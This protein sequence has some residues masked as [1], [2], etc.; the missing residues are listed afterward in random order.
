MGTRPTFEPDPGYRLSGT[1]AA[2]LAA[3]VARDA[4][5]HLLSG[6][7]PEE[8]ELWLQKILCPYPAGADEHMTVQEIQSVGDEQLDRAIWDLYSTVR[9]WRR[10]DLSFPFPRP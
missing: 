3:W 10:G 9:E 2:R 8:R 4:A 5:E 6:L 7:S 1:D